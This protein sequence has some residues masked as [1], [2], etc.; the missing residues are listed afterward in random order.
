MGTGTTISIIVTVLGLILAI[1]FYINDSLDKRIERAVTHPDFIKKV[2]DE[3]RLPFL[4]F[5]EKGTFQSESGGATTFIDRIEPFKEQNRFSGFIV[6]PKNFLKNAPI[7][8]AINSDIPF[9]KPKRVNTIDW[10]FRIPEF[11]G[12]LWA[13]AGK[14]DEPPARLFKLEII[15]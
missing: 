10:Q 3:S 8:Q 6:Y 13:N 1:F 12:T 2:A 11:K 4:I 7:L 15:R 14:Y 9:A 5:D